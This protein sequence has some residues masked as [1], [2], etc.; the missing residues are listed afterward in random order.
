MC[1]NELSRSISVTQIGEYVR[2]DSCDRRFRLDHDQREEA[3]EGVP[4]MRRLMSPMDPVLREVGREREEEWA[5]YLRDQGLRQISRPEGQDSL[6]WER[7]LQRITSLSVGQEAF[8]REVEI[9]GSIGAFTVSGQIDFL[10]LRWR[11]RPGRPVPYL[12][13]VEGKASRKDRTY[14]R[15]Q[16]ATYHLL[17]TEKLSDSTIFIAGQRLQPGEVDAVVARIN[18]ETN[19]AQRIFELNALNLENYRADIRR[20]LEPGGR[21]EQILEGELEEVDYALEPKCDNCVFNV[22]CLPES[23]RQARLELIGLKPGTVRILQGHG[24]ETLTD[25]AHLDLEGETAEEIRASPGF[26]KNLQQ[27]RKDARVRCGALPPAHQAGESF[28]VEF[29]EETGY[30]LLPDHVIGGEP[31]VRVYLKA[32]Y[33]YA[34]DRMVALA[35]HVTTSSGEIDTPLDFWRDRSGDWHRD[36]NPEVEEIEEDGTEHPV[37]GQSV[38]QFR[39]SP[40]ANG[41]EANTQAEQDLLET[42]FEDL[43]EAMQEESASDEAPV[44]F[45]VWS[46]SDLT[47]LIEA[48]SRVGSGL[49]SRLQDILGCRPELEQLIYTSLGDEVEQQYATARTGSA[50]VAATDLSWYDRKTNQPIDY[51]WTREVNGNSIDLRHRFYRDV[52]DFTDELHL[53]S[54]YEWTD[55]DDPDGEGYDFEVRTRHFDTIPVPYWRALWGELPDPDDVADSFEADAIQDY[56]DG[57]SEPHLRA[58][59]EAYVHG[60]RWVEERMQTDSDIPKESLDLDALSDFELGVDE[61]RRAALDV[62]R[63]DQYVNRSDWARRVV[64]PPANKVP[65]G[66]EIPVRHVEELNSTSLSA[67]IDPNPYGLS[68]AALSRRAKYDEGDFV[69]LTPTSSNPQEGPG[70]YQALYGGRTCVI[71]SLNWETGEIRLSIIPAINVQGQREL[72]VLPSSTADYESPHD[73][74]NFPMENATL[75]E[76]PTGYTDYRV[77]TRLSSGLG[78]HVD[79]WF[80]PTGPNVPL[81]P[82][83]GADRQEALADFLEEDFRLPDGN[84]LVEGQRTACLEGLSARIQLLLGPPGTGKT[85][86]TAVAILLR[87]L[88][89]HEP[90]DIIVLGGSTHTAIDTLLGNINDIV[91]QFR[92][93]ASDA[94]FDMPGLQMTKVHSSQVRSHSPGSIDDEIAKD[95]QQV[96]DQERTDDVLLLAGT[97]SSLLKMAEKYHQGDDDHEI[98]AKTLV[99]D[100]ASMM[101]FPDFLALASLTRP[102]GQIFLAGDHNQLAPIVSHEWEEEDRPPTLRY[103]PH[104]S[105]YKAVRR[106]Q[107]IEEISDAQVTESHLTHTFRLPSQVR[108]LIQPVYERDGVSLE[109]R[110]RQVESGEEIDDPFAYVMNQDE[111]LFLVLHDEEISTQY[112][113]VEAELIEQIVQKTDD[114]PDESVALVTPHRAQRSHLESRLQS[115]REVGVIDTVNGLQGGERDTIIVSGTVSDP[116]SISQRAKFVLGL[117]RSNVAFSRPKRRLIVIVSR[118]LTDHIASD[119]EHYEASMLWKSLRAT[120]TDLIGEGYVEVD[121]SEI[122]YQV[123]QA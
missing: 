114:H 9:E 120:C 6:S 28:D 57:A 100:E 39:T 104:V 24:I 118:T 25:L 12:L 105:A 96:I 82:S 108:Q 27:L 85:T 8:A 89:Q 64:Q 65:D 37:E 81:A 106:L 78:N 30:P 112:N 19:Q 83:V 41:Y 31:T 3:M 70:Y 4:H 69:R 107:S 15:I 101:L 94:G 48:C 84:Q 33:D 111:G 63:L 75:G 66:N 52:F 61:V 110:E 43:V 113:P 5:Q 56:R 109:G 46:R 90:G 1:E 54:D 88:Q 58:L 74:S 103:Q 72:Y 21:F 20:R 16:V 115:R 36:P 11:D 13:L 47:Q 91:G 95:M 60:L 76:A 32:E 93:Q 68:L 98:E 38:V 29:Y 117:E 18:E 7:F 62:V 50:L 73:E 67:T 26:S 116:S 34:E 79:A 10:A 86:T 71:D 53:D 119:V 59:L 97:T 40:W 42:F 17:V 121:S 23:A 87:V 14:H 2:F 122:D 44:H 55:P 35:A 80:D 22:H 77:D 123:F 45:Y 99:V 49:L 102:S 92:T 51:H